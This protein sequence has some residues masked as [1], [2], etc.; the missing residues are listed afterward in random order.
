M[1][2]PF[3]VAFART[4]SGAICLGLAFFL[5]GKVVDDKVL[6]ILKGFEGSF[7]LVSS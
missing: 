6:F 7:R 3:A 4:R 5:V 2:L 1:L